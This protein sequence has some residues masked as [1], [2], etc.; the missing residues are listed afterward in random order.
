MNIDEKITKWFNE[1]DALMRSKIDIN[2]FSPIDGLCVAV[3]HSAR[4][5]CSAVLLLLQNKHPTPA[6]A[7]L[8]CLFELSMKLTWC[9]TLPA[10]T[11]DEEAEAGDVAHESGEALTNLALHE[12]RLL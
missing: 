3:L 8:R 7:L 10:N 1:T 4:D 12:L 5:Y 2:K 11:C 6:K 9:L